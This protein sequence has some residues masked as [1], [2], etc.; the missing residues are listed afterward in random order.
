MVVW[1]AVGLL[2]VC[3][4]WGWRSGVM[5][6]LFELAGLVLAIV[7]SARFASLVT[8]WLTEHSAMDETAALLASYFLVFIAA[9]VATRLIAKMLTQLIH[10]TP[11]G[12][13]DRIGGAVCGV[14]LGSLLLSVGLIAVSNAPQGDSVRKAFTEQPVGDVIYHAAPSL[15]QGVQKLFGGQVDEL[16]ERA[17]EIGDEVIEKAGEKVDEHS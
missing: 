2:A 8:P 9:L 11:L 6:R 12:L 1:V 4:F 7:L 3:G 16:W 13:V 15:Y 17:T 5:Q 10:W 14:L